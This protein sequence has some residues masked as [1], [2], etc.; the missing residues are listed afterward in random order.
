MIQILKFTPPHMMIPL[1]LLIGMTFHVTS[2]DDQVEE[3]LATKGAH[4][5][6]S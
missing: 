1:T 2:E 6:H 3:G 5:P 4:Q